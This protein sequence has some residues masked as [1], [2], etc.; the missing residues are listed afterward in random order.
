M[1]FKFRNKEYKVERDSHQFILFEKYIGE[2]G[3]V[4]YNTIGYYKDPY[5]LIQKLVSLN[6]LTDKTAKS[7]LSEL[8]A[9][10]NELS[11]A[12]LNAFEKSPTGQIQEISNNTSSPIG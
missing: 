2:K 10:C 8:H 11:K 5:Y 9:T 6:L 7:M 12:L 3:D 4:E 1:Y